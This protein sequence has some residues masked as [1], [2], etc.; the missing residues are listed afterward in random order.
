[1]VVIGDRAFGI[2]R[3]VREG[4]FRASGSGRFSYSR[5]DIPEETIELA[6]QINSE[7]EQQSVA[8]DFVYDEKK[9]KFLIVEISY[10]YSIKAYYKC[11]GYWDT[12]LKWNDGK[13][14][15]EYFMIEDLLNELG[16]STR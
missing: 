16:D 3:Y 9:D 15:P 4:G 5:K 2:K 11:P 1:V 14:Y 10:A 7:L 12:D 6:F 8:F 13:F